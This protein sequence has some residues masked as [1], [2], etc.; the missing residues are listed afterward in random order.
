MKQT[1]RRLV[2]KLLLD[3]DLWDKKIPINIH[4]IVRKSGIELVIKPQ[5]DSKIGQ[6][7]IIDSKP[8]ITLFE[9]GN[10]KRDRFT[11]AHELGH[12]LYNHVDETTQRLMRTDTRETGQSS[13]R[14]EVEANLFAAELLVPIWAMEYVFKEMNLTTIDEWADLFDVSRKMME[15]RLENLKRTI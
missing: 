1:A 5:T 2:N 12:Y 10:A 3:N 7:E 9:T 15:I 6:I 13:D 14:K 8:T 4:D 11:L